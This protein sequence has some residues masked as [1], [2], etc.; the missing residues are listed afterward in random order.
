M[1]GLV[2]CALAGA[3]RGRGFEPRFVRPSR[4]PPVRPPPPPPSAARSATGTA[5]A[6]G[7][8]SRLHRF[9]LHPDRSTQCAQAYFYPSV[10]NLCGEQKGNA[11]DTAHLQQRAP[12][13]VPP[14]VAGTASPLHIPP[15]LAS[16]RGIRTPVFR[17]A[18]GCTAAAVYGP[19]A[20][21]MHHSTHEGN[22]RAASIEPEAGPSAPSQQS[23]L[24]HAYR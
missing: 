17:T 8:V 13:P 19:E 3:P 7:G 4:G 16:R 2:V 1:D 21:I 14:C 6:W 22:V 20:Y 11:P 23:Q 12:P 5:G 9:F 10:R 18:A 24:V 15:Q